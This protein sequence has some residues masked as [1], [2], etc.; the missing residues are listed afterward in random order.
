MNFLA[1]L[2]LMLIF[3]SPDIAKGGLELAISRKSPGTYLLVFARAYGM[4]DTRVYAILNTSTPR[5]IVLANSAAGHPLIWPDSD[6]DRNFGAPGDVLAAL[7]ASDTQVIQPA[8]RTQ[9]MHA[10]QGGEREAH[11]VELILDRGSAHT[12]LLVL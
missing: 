1:L 5:S 3:T 2:M 10:K 9:R 4:A 11:E 12:L 8:G 7:K 6:L